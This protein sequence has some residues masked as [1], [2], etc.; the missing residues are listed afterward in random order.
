LSHGHLIRGIGALAVDALA[1][2]TA[3]GDP[4]GGV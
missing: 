3:A 4:K 2:S 1:A